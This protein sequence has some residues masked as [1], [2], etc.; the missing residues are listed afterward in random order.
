VTARYWCVPH[1]HWDREWYLSFQDF[2]WRL[3]KTV[4]EIVET[5]EGDPGFGHFM[6][7]GQAVVLEDYLELRPT[8]RPRL[9]ALI[10]SGRLAVGP[11]YLQPDDILVSGESLIRNLEK[12][13][14]LARS[15]G[16]SMEIGYLPDSFGHVGA[17]PAVLR[18]F[19]IASASLMRGPGWQLD[20]SFFRWT[21]KDGSSV[22]VAHL[23][24]GYGN[25]AD[26]RLE[27]TE[28]LGAELE[29]LAER[30]AEAIYP[31]V[32]LLVMQGTDHRS[33]S[34]ALPAALRLAGL[35]PES[36]I[37][38]LAEYIDAARP[39]LPELQEWKGELIEAGRQ[40]IL[41]GV[42]SARTWIKRADQAAS[43]LL[44]REAEPLE[45]LAHRLGAGRQEAAIGLAW[46]WLLQNHPH[47]SICGCS[48]DRVHEDMRYRFAQAED[49]GRNARSDSLAT[50]AR[51]VDSSFVTGEQAVIGLNPGRARSEAELSFEIADFRPG[52]WIEDEEG[53]RYPVQARSLA[54]G[55]SVIFQ[56]S[57]KP[58]QLRFALRLVKDGSVPMVAGRIRDA[59]LI[60]E[61]PTLARV[62]L[63]F[64]EAAFGR[65]DWE[66]FV[67]SALPELDRP[68]LETVKV[69]GL[70][71]GHSELMFRAP[72]PAFG[73]KAFALKIPKGREA[74]TLEDEEGR[75]RVGGKGRR[76]FLENPYLRV[77][78]EDGGGL[79]ITDRLTGKAYRGLDR[80]S[81][82]GDRGD[83]Y[84]YDP[85]SRDLVVD[86]PASIKVSVELWGPARAALRI[87]SEYR[88]PARLEEDRERRSRE[89][90]ALR[91]SRLVSLGAE[92]RRVEIKAEVDN[93]AKDHRLRIG[94]ALPR[95]A[96]AVLAGSS[97][98]AA[99]RGAAR[100]DWLR[101][102]EAPPATRPF[103][104]YVAASGIAL[105]AKGLREYE[106]RAGKAG[107]PGTTG[108]PDGAELSI[109]LLRC[110]GWLSRGD[111]RLRK[112]HAGPGI[113]TPGAQE[114]G[115]HS[116]EYAIIPYSG[117]ISAAALQREWE[118]YSSAAHTRLVPPSRGA[119]L[120]SGASVL[121]WDDAE[122]AF[123][124]LRAVGDRR[125]A[126]RFY[127]LGG[128][129]REVSLRFALPFR[130]LVQTALDGA[131]LADDARGGASCELSPDGLSA[132]ARVR[133]Y[134]IHTLEL[135]W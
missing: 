66:G 79:E 129:D 44:E 134:G 38:S 57:F 94:F 77:E 7:D 132:I 114:Q 109:T 17:L 4:D 88:L 50:L 128:V 76:L 103:A 60:A 105:L 53:R 89:R 90:A 110:V 59:R 117:G 126:L 115:V 127:D 61:S 85:P 3:A 19:G 27:Q 63:E 35:E 123:S 34:K 9:E 41:A 93:R 135:R 24:D 91:V 16:M 33:V 101:G 73:A 116:F 36:R 74:P 12:G 54:G 92:A 122:L 118:D 55:D 104:G 23:I 49:L 45:A 133:A 26:L 65:F 37:A 71:A 20:R 130:F 78:V 8:M 21:S 30:Q 31:G 25:G 82:S 13:R 46:A 58:G 39:L 69:V 62:E 40:P 113:E 48:I 97:F 29:A 99:E 72:L 15:F 22:L 107:G 64:S 100:S 119:G 102:P 11:W 108:R 84:N 87:E 106:L 67:A 32:P 98:E 121:E 52:S 95:A 1:S 124:S 47:D 80:L 6:L 10:S 68:G 83:E 43:I 2:R 75:A 86:R 14:A 81:D 51:A 120:R 111:L 18:G 28:S 42:A 96:T 56:E 112:D 131:P 5:L 70:R 125:L